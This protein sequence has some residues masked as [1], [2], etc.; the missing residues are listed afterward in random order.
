MSHEDIFTR[1][2]LSREETDDLKQ[3]IK[4]Q[5]YRVVDTALDHLDKPE[6]MLKLKDAIIAINGL[7]ICKKDS[8]DG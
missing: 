2:T 4:D 7:V 3:N 5:L 6:E 8:K 1:P